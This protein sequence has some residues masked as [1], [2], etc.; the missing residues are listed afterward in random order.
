[1]TTIHTDFNMHSLVE[2]LSYSQLKW[3]DAELSLGAPF[4][5]EKVTRTIAQLE[6]QERGVCASCGTALDSTHEVTTLVFGPSS[7]RKKGSFCG[8]DCHSA[9][10]SKLQ[11]MR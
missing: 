7:F 5:K 9:F 11:T 4:L 6:L 2:S 8:L 3:L 1:M 10:V